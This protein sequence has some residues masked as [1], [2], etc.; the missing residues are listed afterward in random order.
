MNT[1]I[2]SPGNVSSSVKVISSTP[3]TTTSSSSATQYALVRAQLPGAGGAP[4]QTVTFIR[5]IGP[6]ASSTGTSGTTVTVTPQQMAALLKGQQGQ[7]Q[8]QKVIGAGTTQTSLSTASGIKLG[9]T[10]PSK[11]VSVQF[12]PK[13]GGINPLKNINVSSLLGNK[14]VTTQATNISPMATLVSAGSKTH[15]S[16]SLVNQFPAVRPH[17][18]SGLTSLTMLSAGNKVQTVSSSSTTTTVA[19]DTVVTTTKASTTNTENTTTS[20]SNISVSYAVESTPTTDKTEAPVPVETENE[21]PKEEAPSENTQPLDEKQ[22]LT[23]NNEPESKKTMEVYEKENTQITDVKEEVKDEETIKMDVDS[24]DNIAEENAV[25]VEE[26]IPVLSDIK[27]EP[28]D[29]SI[30]SAAATTLAQLASIATSSADIQDTPTSSNILTDISSNPLSTLAA[31]ASSSLVAP[32]A[33]NNIPNGTKALNSVNSLSVKKVSIVITI[34]L[35][36][37]LLCFIFCKVRNNKNEMRF[38]VI[39]N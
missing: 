29:N 2:L 14:A 32:L 3:A 20:T 30:E 38:L 12:P 35:L 39:V 16:I 6:N 22:P 13:V 18:P 25:K 34:S 28:P 1:P 33:K 15:S 10:S 24:N 27:L 5:A 23:V 21:I 11:L 26:N 17:L 19:P 37:L 4:P 36:L 7:S 8:V 31:L 9:Q